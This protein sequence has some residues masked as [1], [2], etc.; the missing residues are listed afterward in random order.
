[1]F[2]NHSDMTMFKMAE[3]VMATMDHTHR[4]T[5]TYNRNPKYIET[6]D[7]PCGNSCL[8]NHFPSRLEFY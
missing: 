4:Y 2:R 5:I 7:C 6:Y 3:L 8:H 1:M